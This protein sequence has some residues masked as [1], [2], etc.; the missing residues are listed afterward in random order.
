MQRSSFLKRL[1]GIG[2]AATLPISI[3]N[4]VEANTSKVELPI[5]VINKKVWEMY[6]AF[7]NK[8]ASL[9][10]EQ[11]YISLQKAYDEYSFIFLKEDG[12]G[13]D[14]ILERAAFAKIKYHLVNGNIK[15]ADQTFNKYFG[16]LMKMCRLHF[17]SDGRYNQASAYK[18]YANHLLY[19]GY[20]SKAKTKIENFKQL[21]N[22]YALEKMKDKKIWNYV[23]NDAYNGEYKFRD[24]LCSNIGYS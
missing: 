15:Q 3:V 20:V 23:S 14:V 8:D 5:D 11:D 1:I 9:V 16:D 17:N 13:S 4:K 7:V 22:P 21:C 18:E 2:A 10:S 19:A 6:K 24:N 12:I